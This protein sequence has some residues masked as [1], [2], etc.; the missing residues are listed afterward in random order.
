MAT[1]GEILVVLGHE[2]GT[3]MVIVSFALF[4]SSSSKGIY[5]LMHHLFILLKTQTVGCAS[6]NLIL[7]SLSYTIS[8]IFTHLKWFTP[9]DSDESW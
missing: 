1:S 9:L 2:I 5:K 8:L 3:L 4:W 7:P 6:A